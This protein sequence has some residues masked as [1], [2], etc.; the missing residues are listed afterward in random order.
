V[1]NVSTRLA[2]A[3]A[4]KKR[5]RAL[6][7]AAAL[8]FS[9]CGADI[10]SATPDSPGTPVG[11][12]NFTFAT[13]PGS[14]V[15]GGPFQFVINTVT[16]SPPANLGIPSSVQAW[17]VETA[18]EISPGGTYVYQLLSQ[19]PS[20]IGG[21]I[22]DG[23]NWLKV[24]NSGGTSGTVTFTSGF[25]GFA[26]PYAS[27]NTDAKEVGQ[28]IQE[29]I[30]SLQLLTPIAAIGSHG[31]TANLVNYLITNANSLSYYWLHNDTN[32]DQVFRVPG[33]IVGAGLPGL[34]LACG[35]LI[36]L[37]R[38]RRQRFA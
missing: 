3:S 21:L 34:L 37:A 28:A 16:P 24:T 1:A 23:L 5:W 13:Y 2:H 11:S 15:G 33:P 26:A 29:A 30:W 25:L 31:D 18:Q 20:Q 17:C 4:E 38:R 12:V 27:W 9:I 32:Q 7:V 36:A 10:A 19:A 8:L 6:P 22:Q 14:A 35:G